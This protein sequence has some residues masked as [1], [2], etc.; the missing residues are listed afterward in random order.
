MAATQAQLDA[1]NATIA[2][3]ELEVEYDGKRIRY[4][5]TQALLLA[6][7]DL[8]SQLAAQNAQF[9][10]PTSAVAEFSRD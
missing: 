10:T 5:S 8:V 9:Y 6:R 2:S 3:G 4:Q 1:L 7:A